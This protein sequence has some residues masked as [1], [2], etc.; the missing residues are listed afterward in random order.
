MKYCKLIDPIKVPTNI[1]VFRSIDDK[2]GKYEQIRLEPGQSYEVPDD[3]RYLHSLAI[4]KK[5][6][7]YSAELEN[8][9]KESGVEYEIVYCKV[10]GGKRKDIEYPVVEVFEA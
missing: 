9:L 7:K 4:A 2:R 10:C 6:Q 5:K 3:E 1:P 8:L